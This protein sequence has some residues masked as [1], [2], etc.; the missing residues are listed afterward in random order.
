[1]FELFLNCMLVRFTGLGRRTMGAY[2]CHVPGCASAPERTRIAIISQ[3]GLDSKTEIAQLGS[4][5]K[6]ETIWILLAQE[7][8]TDEL[9]FATKAN[10]G[11]STHY[12]LA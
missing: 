12:F 1:M 10:R 7:N 6:C 8:C 2:R 11:F 5:I 9:T 4:R 3:V